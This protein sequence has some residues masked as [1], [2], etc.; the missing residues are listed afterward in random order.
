MHRS[1]IAGSH[2]TV[3]LVFEE[4]AKLF[5]S[6]Y[7]FSFSLSLQAFDGINLKHFSHCD[8]GA[9]VSHCM[10]NAICICVVIHDVKHL[11]MYLFAISILY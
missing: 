6:C 4:L 1:V 10:Y 3:S 5:Q 11:F 2:A 9:V 8:R 7:G